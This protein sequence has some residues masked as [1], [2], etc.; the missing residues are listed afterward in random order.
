MLTE[1]GALS[2]LMSGSGPSVSGIFLN[3]NDAEQAKNA[4]LSTNIRAYRCKT[5]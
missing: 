1:C 3:E 4:L 5:M 2:A